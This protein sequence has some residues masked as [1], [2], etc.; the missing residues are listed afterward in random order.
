[1]SV[2]I[3]WWC[4]FAMSVS[5]HPCIAFSSNFS[6]QTILRERGVAIIINNDE[7]SDISGLDP[8]TGSSVD[9]D[10][11]FRVLKFVGFKDI[12]IRNNMRMNDMRLLM[13]KGKI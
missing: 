4:I 13:K 7:F 5:T 1:M 11:L 9:R 3:L 6:V 12:R 10:R 8:R 2:N